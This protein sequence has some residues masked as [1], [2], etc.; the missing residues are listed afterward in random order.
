[1]TPAAYPSRQTAIEPAYCHDNLSTQV[2][3]LCAKLMMHMIAKD[4][5][6]A[7]SNLL[8]IGVEEQ[9]RVMDTPI[10]MRAAL[11]VKIR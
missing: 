6:M 9:S 4:T 5:F 7:W 10:L 1:M 3:I 8:V 11:V 2:V